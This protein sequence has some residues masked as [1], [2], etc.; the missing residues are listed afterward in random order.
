MRHDP[1][2][3]DML[4]PVWGGDRRWRRADKASTGVAPICVDEEGNNSIV[5]VTGTVS[6]LERREPDHDCAVTRGE[7]RV[8]A[9]GG[10]R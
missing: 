8:D 1:N 10:H 7:R 4:L 3:P 9:A 2:I 5:I 6:K